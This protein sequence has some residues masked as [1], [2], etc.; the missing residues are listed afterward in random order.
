MSVKLS[1]ISDR[2]V[3]LE[4]VKVS[5]YVL[6]NDWYTPWVCGRPLY[7]EAL[8]KLFKM[9]VEKF[10]EKHSIKIVKLKDD[11][12]RTWNRSEKSTKLIVDYLNQLSVKSGGKDLFD[13]HTFHFNSDVEYTDDLI[14]KLEQVEN[15][16]ELHDKLKFPIGINETW[17]LPTDIVSG[18]DF[19]ISTG[20]LL[21]HYKIK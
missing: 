4:N 12:Y 18:S 11:R 2:L 8:A 20:Y 9:S 5:N 19:A 3:S 13:Y 10:K 17:S 16:L 14:K 6:V 1:S 7:Y 21:V 15:G